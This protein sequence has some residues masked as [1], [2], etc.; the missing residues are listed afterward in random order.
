VLGNDAFV[1]KVLHYFQGVESIPAP[2]VVFW[3]IVCHDLEKPI[4]LQGL[5]EIMGLCI[6]EFHKIIQRREDGKASVLLSVG[7]R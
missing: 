4:C 7:H 5:H 2:G 1:Q 6:V 3:Y